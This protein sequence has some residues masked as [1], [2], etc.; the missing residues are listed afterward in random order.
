MVG[1]RV[2]VTSDSDDPDYQ[3]RSI[4]DHRY[5]HYH[6]DCDSQSDHHRPTPISRGKIVPIFGREVIAGSVN[7]KLP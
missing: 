2:R 5:A 1:L 6:E 3:P 4:G 7:Q